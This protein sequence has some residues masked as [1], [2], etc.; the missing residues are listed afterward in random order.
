MRRRTSTWNLVVWLHKDDLGSPGNALLLWVFSR[1][2][3]DRRLARAGDS[4]WMAALS[5][6]EVRPWAGED[7][8]M[9]SNSGEGV[10]AGFGDSNPQPLGDGLP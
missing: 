6:P 1:A 3:L 2:E 10:G 7:V 5:S 9:S 4:S 8:M